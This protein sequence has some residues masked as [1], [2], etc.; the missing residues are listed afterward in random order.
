VLQLA[1]IT[2]NPYPVGSKDELER[3]AG[4]LTYHAVHERYHAHFRSF[5]RSEGYYDL[6]LITLQGDCIYTVF[7]ELDY[8]TNLLSGEWA[9]SG[10]GK[11]FRAALAAPNKVHEVEFEPY[12]PSNGALASFICTGVRDSAGTPRGVLCVQVP[13]DVTVQLA[14]DGARLESCVLAIEHVCA[15][16]LVCARYYRTA[17]TFRS[18]C[19]Y[20][21]FNYI[22]LDDLH[23][24]STPIALYET[25]IAK[26]APR[27]LPL[28]HTHTHHPQSRSFVH[29]GLGADLQIMRC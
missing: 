4:P 7:K 2:N 1:Y 18:I 21:V 29:L 6:F 17:G 3:A 28:E 24:T 12:A 19:R 10:L 25:S 11:A 16:A 9:L 23:M 14:A 22:C 5:I 26:N 20:H 27:R 13:F 15:T 8:A